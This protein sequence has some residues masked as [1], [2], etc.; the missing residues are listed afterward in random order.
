MMKQ[1]LTLV[2]VVV[3]ISMVSAQQRYF[4]ERYI[5][6]Q[7]HLNPVLINPGATGS[8]P[9][10]RVIANYRNKWADF[11]G[12]PR[13]FILSY[14]GPIGNRLGFGAMLLTDKAGAL[15]TT[16]G[17]GS[18]S[19]TLDSPTNRL[20]F[21]LAGE[22]V[23]HGV[24]GGVLGNPL[25]NA[26]DVQLLERINGINYFDVTFGVYGEYNDQIIYGLTLPGL[27]NSKLDADP[28]DIESRDLGYI[29]H[30]GYRYQPA[31]TD[32]TVEPSIIYK[33]INNV[34]T[35]FDIN[36]LMRF[37]DDKFTGGVTYSVGADDRLGF[38]IGTRINSVN[39]F[40]SYNVSRSTFQT[41]N[42]GSHELSLRFDI[43][44]QDKPMDTMNV[45]DD[46]PFSLRHF[47]QLPLNVN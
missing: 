10:H 27:L 22:Y 11:P 13:S 26:S 29:F 36:V 4:D 45:D 19:Y 39:F 35:H 9:Y 28:D 33:S 23:Q 12:T 14:D 7:S 46:K 15:E 17:Q 40:Y 44:R 34:P 8:S 31:N 3:S 16:K 25:V 32:F 2:V 30:L 20:G 38:L 18:L 47:S 21:G 42:N 1:V 37:I 41:Y 24:D 6:T 5:S 43:G